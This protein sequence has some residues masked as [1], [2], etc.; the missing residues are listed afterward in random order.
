MT[1]CPYNNNYTLIFRT[2]WLKTEGVEVKKGAGIVVAMKDD[3]PE[4][5]QITNVYI[6]NGN[7]AF[8]RARLYSC[9]FVPH[10]HGYTLYAPNSV[11]EQLFY[12]SKLLCPPVLIGKPHAIGQ[13]FII[14]PHFVPYDT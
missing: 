12:M 2:K 14:L 10:Y 1:G 7:T 4:V 5:A 6:I 8:L 11:C 13:D 9:L 3:L